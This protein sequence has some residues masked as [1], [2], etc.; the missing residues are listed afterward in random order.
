MLSTGELSF[1]ALTLLALDYMIR[2]ALAFRVIM[3]KRPVGTTLAWLGVIL[4]FPFAGAVIY[5]TFGELR[6]GRRR[7][8]YAARLHEPYQRWLEGLRGRAEVTWAETDGGETAES[9][10]RV[11]EAVG[12]IPAQADN[13]WELIS[14]AQA[15]FRRLIDDI[16]KAK[17]TCHLEFYIWNAGG[18]AD[19][20][21]EA[22][23]RASK[24]GVVCRVL[25]DGVGSARFLRS[26]DAQRLR[27]GG[28]SVQ[29]AMPVNLV[30]MLFVR[31]DL[32]LHRKIVVIDGEV[33]YTGSQNLVDP[34]FF[35]KDAGVGE[36]VDAMVR[37]KG[38]AVEALGITFLE[39][40]ELE[41]G[42]GLNQLEA[43]GDV[44]PIDAA[45]PATV[46]VIPSG[47]LVK[48]ETIQAVLLMA[49]Y[50]ARHELILTTP[51]F[52]PDETLVSALASA[53]IRGVDVTLVLPARVDSRLARLASRP[54]MGALLRA[55]VKIAQFRGGLLH[56]KSVTIDGKMSLFGSLNL[57]PRSL[58]LNFEI[59]LAVYD[60]NFTTT[61]R[62]LQQ[63]YIRQSRFLDAV[64]WDSRSRLKRFAENVA[65][66][67][68]PLL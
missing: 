68:S 64:A 59:T 57:D 28:V 20:V 53:A 24:R 65:R 33:A 58:V 1:R 44:H 4:L 18:T 2:L 51:Y 34:R 66:L 29:A 27:E 32:R 67:L 46:Q 40:W 19:E 63:S 26:R 3:R 16:D 62:S 11:A 23:V 38:P 22:L 31:F 49:I 54:H 21:G 61:L 9:L 7:A 50:Q 12:G 10:S 13:A 55:G 5:L 8:D 39:D 41:T 43:H 15:V 37:I 56:T 30:R 52:V 42:E 60:R 48:E 17:R 14:D 45:G 6:L 47:P 36:W 35:K 25:I